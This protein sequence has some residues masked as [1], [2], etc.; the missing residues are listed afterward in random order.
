MVVCQLRWW[1]TYDH[2]C[3]NKKQKRLLWKQIGWY[4]SNGWK[5]VMWD[6]PRINSKW[7]MVQYQMY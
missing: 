7:K 2:E 5:P 3:E 1:K 6:S 4:K